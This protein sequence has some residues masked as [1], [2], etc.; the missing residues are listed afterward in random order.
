MVLQ[1]LDSDPRNILFATLHVFTYRVFSS[2]ILTSITIESRLE[3]F[4]AGAK[5]D[6]YS[7]SDSEY[8]IRARK[9]FAIVF[10]SLSHGPSTVHRHSPAAS[11]TVPLIQLISVDQSPNDAFY[12]VRPV[13]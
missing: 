13:L 1:A 12:C 7:F 10:P 4:K 3:T 9:L 8:T 11:Q 5:Q 2:K 6:V